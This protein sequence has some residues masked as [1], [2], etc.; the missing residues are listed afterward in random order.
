MVIK[1]VTDKMFYILKKYCCGGDVLLNIDVTTEVPKLTLYI[2]KITRYF[3][4]TEQ[5]MII[6]TFIRDQSYV[7]AVCFTTG[8][9]AITQTL[10]ISG[11][12]SV[13]KFISTFI[14]LTQATFA[15]FGVSLYPY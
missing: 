3:Y 10:F 11:N 15:V 9:D 8:I 4:V 2:N 14:L 12:S 5:L 6:F 1:F 7:V 13:L